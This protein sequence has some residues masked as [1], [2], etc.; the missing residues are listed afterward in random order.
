META[1]DLR[2]TLDALT[3]SYESEGW[4]RDELSSL[5]A[6][7]GP[8]H[9]G[10]I[11]RPLASLQSTVTFEGFAVSDEERKHIIQFREDHML[12]QFFESCGQTGCAPAGKR[13]NEPGWLARPGVKPV[14][15]VRHQP[16]LPSRV[17]ERASLG[18]A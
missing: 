5:E 17:T 7:F 18:Y 1:L 4:N 14:A 3:T 12:R 2:D 6:V 8:H 16:G 11:A 13:F 9:D 15:Q 10:G